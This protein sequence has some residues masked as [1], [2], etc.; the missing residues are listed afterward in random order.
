MVDRELWNK[1]QD[2]LSGRYENRTK[3]PKRHFT[4]TG[5]IRCGHCGCSLV[6]QLQ[7]GKYIYYHCSGAKGKCPEPYTREE[8]FDEQLAE[9]L[10][11]LRFDDEVLEW[12]TGALRASHDDEKRYDD[13]VVARLRA[14]YDKLQ[15]RIDAMYVDKLDGRIDAAFFDRK[16]ADWR[17][18]Q[19]ECLA[20]I[21]RHQNA[22]QT[23]FDEGVQLLELAQKAG[24]MF[25]TQPSNQK[26]RLLGFVLSNCT[27]EGGEL[28]ATYRQPFDLLAKNVLEFSQRKRSGEPET[29]ISEIWL[30][31]LGSNQGPND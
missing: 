22:N 7:K 18:E 6:A 26:R 31:D 24:E 8:V 20:T 19:Q 2:I 17:S 15:Q 29:A 14:E 9:V 11:G 4:Y 12:V 10:G 1:V 16:S 5:L 3:R 25:R 28:T 30:P 27:W 21:A 23:Y 13:E